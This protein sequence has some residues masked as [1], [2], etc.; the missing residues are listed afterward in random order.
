MDNDSTLSHLESLLDTWRSGKVDPVSRV[1]WA[2]ASERIA[3]HIE[4][5][6]Q[7]RKNILDVGCG[8]G[9]FLVKLAGEGKCCYGVD[10]LWQTSLKRAQ[11]N[12]YDAGVSVNFCRSVGENLPFIHDCIDTVLC[13][14]TLQHVDNVPATLREIH[15]VLRGEGLLIVSVPQTVRKPIFEATRVYTT[16]FNLRTLKEALT[17]S[18]FRILEQDVCG[19]FPPFSQHILN[20]AYPLLKD[21]RLRKIICWLDTIGA[22]LP[23]IASSI[24]IVAEARK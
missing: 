3:Y 2:L 12:A 22:R 20:L 19:F 7:S 10:P 23:S 17:S 21:H 13:I 6:N 18:G 11:R 8:T 5:H 14:S 24:I 1:Y 4:K 16:H 9:T 15:R